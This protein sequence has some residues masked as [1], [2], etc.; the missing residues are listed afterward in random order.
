VIL[1]VLNEIHQLKIFHLVV[2]EIN[3][4]PSK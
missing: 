3:E 4:R 1:H 2:R